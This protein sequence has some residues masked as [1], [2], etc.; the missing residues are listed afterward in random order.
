[1]K[2][3]T[4]TISRAISFI[5]SAL[6]GEQKEYTS[7]SI[8]RAILM[9]SIPMI[10]EM[11]MESLFAIVD[12][13]FV[14]RVGVN[15]VATVALTESVLMIIYSVAV[16]MSMAVTALVARRIGEKNPERASNAAFQGSLIGSVLGLTLGFA[17]LFFARDILDIMVG[18]EEVIQE[19]VGYTR[20][21]FGSNVVIILLF[22][23]NGIFRGAGDASIAMKS[24][25]LANGINIILDPI[26]IFGIGAIPAFGVKGAAIAT[27]IGRSVGV[28][29]QLFYLMNGK[30]VIRI[31]Y[32][33]I[34]VKW[35]TISEIF[36]IHKLQFS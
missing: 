18:S 31:L 6:A 2:N 25:W 11:V 27:L 22:M 21:M 16:G 34:V 33:N 28:I 3:I 36:K 7:G 8:N 17:G 12:V 23:I 26:L 14:S 32:K 13:F 15:A 1:M 5:K 10:A 20:I 24:L 4:L 19:G 9:L 29:Y 35:H 30:S